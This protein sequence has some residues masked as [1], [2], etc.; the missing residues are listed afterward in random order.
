MATTYQIENVISSGDVY[1]GYKMLSY[2]FYVDPAFSLTHINGR[3]VSAIYEGLVN[4]D[5]TVAYTAVPNITLNMPQIYTGMLAETP[6]AYHQGKLHTSSAQPIFGHAITETED[7][8]VWWYLMCYVST[9]GAAM[10]EGVNHSTRGLSPTVSLTI[11]ETILNTGE[12]IIRAS[13]MFGLPWRSN[14]GDSVEIQT[15]YDQTII[16]T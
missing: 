2:L 5:F 1:V 9:S 10:A 8:W 14:C 4:T 16:V 11:D 12:P 15:G 3:D 6:Y 7:N 13:K